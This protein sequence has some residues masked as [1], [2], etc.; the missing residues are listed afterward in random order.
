MMHYLTWPFRTC[1]V[2][3]SVLILLIGGTALSR[4]NTGAPILL[5]VND[6]SANKFGRYVGE[7]LRAE[8]LNA[9]EVLQLSSLT[10]TD[11]TNHDLTIL[12]ETTLNSSQATLFSNYVNSGG[13]LLALRPDGQIASLFGLGAGAG[14]LSNGYVKINT[15]AVINGEMPGQGLTSATLQIHGPADQYTTVGGSVTLAQLYSSA[16][17]ATVYPAVVSNATGRAIA[18]TYDLAQNVV[19]TRQG[20]PANGDVDTDGDGM[21]R[22]IDLFQTSGGE[23]RGSIGTRSRCHRRMSSSGCLPGWS[24][25]WWGRCG[26]CRSCGTSPIQPR[27]C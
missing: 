24:S 8:G 6:S 3:I 21:V 26:P 17:T 4:A 25:R 12:A 27:R 18:F 5:V 19:Y 13:R 10:A 15:S 2:A 20:N 1:V 14:S 9:F 23:R 16:S 7:I 11:L 22:T